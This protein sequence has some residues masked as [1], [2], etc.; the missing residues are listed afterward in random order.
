MYASSSLRYFNAGLFMG[1]IVQL[2]CFVLLFEHLLWYDKDVCY[3][4]FW[5]H[6]GKGWGTQIRVV[7]YFHQSR[8]IYS[9][10][11]YS[12]FSATRFSLQKAK[13]KST[14]KAAWLKR[15]PGPSSSTV[16]TAGFP[17]A[18]TTGWLRNIKVSNICTSCF[19]LLCCL[20]LNDS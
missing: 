9:F 5:V 16:N 4:I 3:I 11:V 7:S 12:L 17:N 2:K 19:I 15:P 8:A 13:Q 1:Q 18:P 14:L 10:V 6:V 20:W